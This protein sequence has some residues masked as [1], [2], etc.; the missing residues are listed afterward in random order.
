MWGLL[1]LHW[2]HLGEGN[3]I[4]FWYDTWCGNCAFKD[5]FPTLFSVASDK[6]TSMA[7][8]MVVV[9]EQIQWN[10]SFSRAAQDWEMDSFKAFFNLLY[11]TKPSNQLLDLLWWVPSGKGLFSVR[12][13][14]KALAQEQP[15]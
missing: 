4:K 12:A 14:Y 2:L 7:K 6:E 8:V 9:G 11:S 13:F 10:I 5:L 15:S 1:S 3:R